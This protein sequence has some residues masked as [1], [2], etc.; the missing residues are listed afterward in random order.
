MKDIDNLLDRLSELERVHLAQK[1]LGDLPGEK[2][3]K[4]L[5]KELPDSGLAIMMNGSNRS[6]HDAQKVANTALPNLCI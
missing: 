5:E 3:A 2:R 6:V 4:L 1:I